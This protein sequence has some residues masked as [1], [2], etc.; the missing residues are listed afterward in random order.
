TNH[1]ASKKRLNLICRSVSHDLPM[2]YR[3]VNDLK[4][5]QWI[6]KCVPWP[7]SDGHGVDWF[8]FTFSLFSLSLS[9]PFSTLLKNVQPVSRSP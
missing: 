9:L 8:L 6:P 2:I 5:S 3:G 1:L 7:F 4:H